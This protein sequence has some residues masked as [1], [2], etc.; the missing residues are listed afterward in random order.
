MDKIKIKYI[1]KDGENFIVG[2]RVGKYGLSEIE[3]NGKIP[4]YQVFEEI[5]EEI[6]LYKGE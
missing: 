5:K 6:K 4:F 3:F 2:Y 1:K